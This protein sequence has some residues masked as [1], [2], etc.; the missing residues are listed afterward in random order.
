MT[1]SNSDEAFGS[2]M[3]PPPDALPTP[4]S[5]IL[6]SVPQSPH[7][8]DEM[9]AWRDEVAQR[10]NRYRT[11][12]KAPPPRYPSLKLPFGPHESAARATTPE[13]PTFEPIVSQALALGVPEC[14]PLIP[15]EPDVR[16]VPA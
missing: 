16:T 13:V 1:F 4:N 7:T 15:N 11:R 9:G 8:D 6:S 10:L 14:L 12:R 5:E 3:E 2:P